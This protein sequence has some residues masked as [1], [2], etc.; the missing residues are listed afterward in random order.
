MSKVEMTKAELREKTEEE[1]KLIYK[2]EKQAQELEAM[3]E[4]LIKRLQSI[5]EEEKAAF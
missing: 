2:F 3:E 5:Q 1:K 4:Q